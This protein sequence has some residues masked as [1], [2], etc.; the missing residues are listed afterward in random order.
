MPLR[1]DLPPI[2]RG[3]RHAE[4]DARDREALERFADDAQEAGQAAWLR[5]ECAGRLKQSGASPAVE[6][7]LAEAC[8]AHGEIERAHQTL[9]TLGERLAEAK[10]WEPL[11][12]V[13]ERALV[14]GESQA[15]ARLLVRAHEG[16]GKDPERL[17]AMQRAWVLMH[18]DLDLGLLLAVRLGDAGRGDDRRALLAHLLPRFAEEGRNSGLEE[19]ALEFA[20]HSDLD[21]LVR[22]IQTLPSVRGEHA[23]RECRQLLDIAFPRVAQAD[24]A[25]EVLPALRALVTRA[26]EELGPTGPEMFREAVREALMQGPVRELPDPAP[27][28]REARIEDAGTPLPLALE[29]FDAIAALP[30]GRAVH[31]GSFG[32]GRM[33]TNDS[34]TVTIDFAHARGHRMPYAAARR[35]LTTIAADDLRLLRVTD[36]AGVARMIADAPADVVLRALAAMGGEA[37]AQKL[38]VFLVGSGLL[39]A[40]EWTA[41]W[42]RAKAAADK[43]PRIDSSRA[44]EQRYRVAAA[45]DSKDGG[46]PLPPLE[47]RKPVKTNL[48]TIRKFLAQHPDAEPALAQRFGRMV[49][50]TVVDPEADRV[51]RARAGLYFAR[52]YPD[53]REE[54]ADVLRALWEQGLAVTDLTTEDEQL[55]LLEASHAAGVEADAILSALDSR[56]PAVRASASDLQNHLDDSGRA[57]LRRTLLAHAPRYPGAALRLIDDDLSRGVA[58][59]EAWRLLRGSLTLI[60]QSPKP[61]TAEKVLRWLEPGGPFDRMVANVPAPEDTRLQLRVLLRQWRS[62]DRFLFPALD[63]VERLG[64]PDEAEAVRAH[65]QKRSEKLFDKVGQVA[66]DTEL[67]VMTRATWDRLKRELDRLEREL[68]TTIPQSIQKARELGDLR[69]NAEFHSAK[70]KQSNVSKL[71]ASLQQRL[72]RARFVDDAE[73]RDGTVGLGTEIVLESDAQ[74]VVRFWILGEEEHHHGTHVISFQAPVGRALMGRTIGDT[75]ELGEGAERKRYRIVS[76]ERRL[77]PVETEAGS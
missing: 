2:L 39:K 31:H 20:E 63:A 44:F 58:G 7:L 56:F 69:E 60:E 48:A 45:A 29:R 53:R 72:A 6:Y 59:P 30:P 34:E 64:L 26:A 74:D 12:G 15:A 32:A 33:A 25:G 8:R 23:L 68:R 17:D 9:L 16:L 43:D 22:L 40:T 1:D 36:P 41:F 19:V 65:R 4:L 51:D 5:D 10:R 38:K 11:A 27:V 76:V 13:A 50:R 71:V 14:M 52:W 42:R 37:D 28:L 21:A 75:I 3:E 47:P 73:F 70:L 49:A 57:E 62:S 77:P 46:A 66:E 54:W 24:R 18:Q 61:S 35:T 55:T 67:V